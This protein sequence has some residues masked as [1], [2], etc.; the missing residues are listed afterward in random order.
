VTVYVEDTGKPE[1]VR[2]CRVECFHTYG[3]VL[4]LEEEVKQAPCPSLKRFTYE[5][6]PLL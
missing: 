4:R 1:I 3:K 6:P 2:G 5:R